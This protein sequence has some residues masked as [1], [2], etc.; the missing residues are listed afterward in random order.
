M[1][2]GHAASYA[3]VI[4]ENTLAK[5]LPVEYAAF[6]Q[7]L[8]DGGSS[9]DDFASI[10]RGARRKECSVVSNKTFKALCDAFTR[11]FKGL[12]LELLYHNVEDD[13]SRY[14]G[15]DG[16][17]WHVDG[18]WVMSPGAKMLGGKNWERKFYVTFG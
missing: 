12:S 1:G 15:V 7:A 13:G 14:D 17:F 5:L 4:E 2:M 8:A 6:E 18:L 3:D 10:Q 11:K 9:L 16:A